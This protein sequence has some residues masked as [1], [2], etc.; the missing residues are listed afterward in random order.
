GSGAGSVSGAGSGR[1]GSAGGAAEVESRFWDAVTRQD[2]ETVATTLAV[3]PSAG[4]DTVVPA[5]SAWHR[6][7][8]DQARINTWTYQETWKPLTLPTTHQPHQTW[9]IAIP[10]TQTHHPHITNILTNL[11]HHGITPIPLPLNHTHTN[12]QHLHHTLQQAR[13]HT[14]QPI[15]GLLSLL[16]LDETP[17]PHHPHTPT[18]TLLNL[19]LTQTHTQ[20]HPPTPLWYA[21]TNAT[22]THPN[23]PLTHP[24]QAQ[25]WGLARTTLL[26]HPTHTA[27]IIDLP[28]TPTP[29]TLHHLTQTLTQPHHQTQL[30]IRTTGTHTRRLTPTTLTPTHHSTTPH[31]TTH[32]TTL[33]TGGTGAL[34][35]HL[36]H[37]LTTHQ[38][39]QHL[40]LTSRTGPHTPHAQHL[41]NQ[42]QQKGIHLTITT[43]D[44]SNPDQLQQLLNTIPPQHPLTTVIHTAGT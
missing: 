29:H 15:T 1:A 36:T 28:T 25:T 42:L 30:A 12:P 22:T 5:L 26:E 35:T 40:L 8:H 41:T 31:T 44:T 7:Q 21:T 4:L 33:I 27:G 13:T 23:D 34:A 11:H 19:T 39:T 2:L 10:E 43:C 14:T 9:L 38:P 37:H 17:H 3:P 32:G 18:G 24:T 6:H 20:T 16:A